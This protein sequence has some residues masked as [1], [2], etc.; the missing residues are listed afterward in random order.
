MKGEKGEKANFLAQLYLP[1]S[2]HQASAKVNHNFLNSLIA[3]FV[4]EGQIL[5][6]D[7]RACSSQYIGNTS[8][9]LWHL[10]A[11]LR[12]GRGWAASGKGMLLWSTLPAKNKAIR[13]NRQIVM[14][15]CS[16]VTQTHFSNCLWTC[17][18]FF[19]YKCI[20][21]V[22]KISIA[23]IQFFGGEK[24]KYSLFQL[25]WFLS[26]CRSSKSPMQTGDTETG[27][28][29]THP[30]TY[31]LKLSTHDF[32]IDTRNQASTQCTCACAIPHKNPKCYT[33]L[34]ISFKNLLFFEHF[35]M[36]LYKSNSWHCSVSSGWFH[37][38]Q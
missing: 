28:S 4:Y 38:V 11:S 16:C 27:P 22:I 24:E 32:C 3:S 1:L 2:E 20:A 5:L 7:L 25:F 14:H 6:E 33:T 17:K 8:G 36:F 10:G 30:W 21:K 34:K 37:L 12:G 9:P 13:A 29:W 15:Q 26:R 19:K 31:L 35:Q 18:S 23:Y